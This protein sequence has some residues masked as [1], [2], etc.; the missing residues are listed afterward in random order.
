MISNILTIDITGVTL[1]NEASSS[2]ENCSEEYILEKQINY[3]V[4]IYLT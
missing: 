2:M 1:P 4:Y 3:I